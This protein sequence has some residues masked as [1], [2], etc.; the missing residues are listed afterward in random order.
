M[1]EASGVEPLSEDITPRGTPSAVTVL[2]SHLTNCPATGGLSDQPL[3]FAKSTV[4]CRSASLLKFETQQLHIGDGEVD[5]SYTI[6]QLE[7]HYCFCQLLLASAYLTRYA[8]PRL[9]PR[10]TIIPVESQK[11]PH[12]KKT[13]TTYDYNTFTL[14]CIGLA[15]LFF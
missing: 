12:I 11:R 10:G 1:V 15:V 5:P 13:I 4:A 3:N 6:R 9:A 2:E 7:Q 14:I 8:A